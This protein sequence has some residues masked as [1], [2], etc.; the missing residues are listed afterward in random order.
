MSKIKGDIN[1]AM[2]RDSHARALNQP[3]L[4]LIADILERHTKGILAGVEEK[5]AQVKARSAGFAKAAE[6]WGDKADEL[7][8]E[9]DKLKQRLVNLVA[10]SNNLANNCHALLDAVPSAMRERLETELGYVRYSLHKYE[11]FMEEWRDENSTLET[12]E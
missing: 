7:D 8:R 3:A 5:M 6:S 10:V 12:K 11:E 4:D 9:N 1:K 2:M